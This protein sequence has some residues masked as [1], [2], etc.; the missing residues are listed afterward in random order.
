MAII[1]DTKKELTI[2]NF[3]E[4]ECNV[5]N[6]LR[7]AYT[8]GLNRGL[9]MIEDSYNAL[10]NEN[11]ALKKQIEVL[12]RDLENSKQNVNDELKQQ[13]ERLKKEL[14]ELKSDDPFVDFWNDLAGFEPKDARKMSD[15]Q[16]AY[17]FAKYLLGLNR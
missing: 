10:V 9:F 3:F 7:Q 8:K 13:N 4:Y 12:K 5:D 6:T 17:L 1:S 2:K 15:E 14:E 11:A 16:K